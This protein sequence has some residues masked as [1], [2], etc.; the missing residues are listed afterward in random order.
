RILNVDDN[1]AGRYAI[2]KILKKAGFEVLEAANGTD[3]IT[4]AATRHPDLLL[5]DV[6]LPDISGFEVCQQIKL[7][8][9]TSSILVVHLSATYISPKDRV[10][11]LTKGADGYLVHP[12]DPGELVE[13]IRAFLRIREMEGALRESEERF[14]GLFDTVTSGVAIYQVRNDGVFGKDYIIKDFNKMALEIEGKQKDD[15]IGKS[16]FDLR[17]AVDEYGIIAVFQRVWK[18]GVPEYFPQKIY[19][20]VNYTSWYENRVFRLQNGEVVA[21]YNDVTD[22]I[23]A[24]EKLKTSRIQLAE[25]MG[26]ASLVNWEFD[27]IKG[28]F[29]FDDRFY[30][31]YGTT[32]ERE[33]GYQMTP[34][35]Y[36]KNFVHPDDQYLVADEVN[37][38][39]EATDPGYMSQVEH[40]ILRRDGE[41]RHIVVRLGITKDEN[42]RTIKSHGANQDITE[43]KRAENIR[44]DLLR[45]LEQKNAELDRFAYTVSHDLKSPLT[46]IRGFLSLLNQ[47]LQKN[48]PALVERDMARIS[49]AAE[50]ME[51]MISTMLDLSRS[52][53]S[54]DA[55]VTIP[56]IV[57]VNEAAGLLNESLKNHAVTLVIDNNLPVVSGDR[58]RLLQVMINLLENA[59]KFM[60]D[61]KEPRIEVGIQYGNTGPVFFVRDN[62]IGIRNEEQTK[63]FK[64]FERLNPDVQGTGIGL[65]TV[66]RIIEAHGGKIWVESEG[67]GKGTTFWFTLPVVQADIA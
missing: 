33:G 40:R 57:V 45:E 4:M 8:P 11:G 34:E 50:K 59:I 17:P 1:E 58:Q 19:I 21:I 22:K 16:L 67:S 6:N 65:A 60:G 32:A 42:G 2:T 64:L 62:G 12:V 13:T 25:A 9:E 20:D 55:P 41:I 36:T 56:F 7:N 35:A 37:K 63:I 5:L 15:V 46:T 10:E 52:G 39:I 47:D 31:L 43:R 28:I 3:A 14:R 66:K 53:K 18:T 27:V 29:T 44:E 30:V 54:V 51:R 38:A 24:E 26:L 49:S 61:Q 48:D 23:Q